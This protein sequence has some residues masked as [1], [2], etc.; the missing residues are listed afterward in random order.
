MSHYV[1]SS[2]SSSGKCF[3]RSLETGSSSLC[4]DCPVPDASLRDYQSAAIIPFARLIDEGHKPLIAAPCASGKSWM[5][6]GHVVARVKANPSY[7]CFVLAMAKELIVQNQAALKELAPSIRSGIYCAGLKRKETDF[8]ITF[9][10]A[11]SLYRKL[12]LITPDHELLLDEADQ[13]SLDNVIAKAILARTKKIG[14]FTGT[15]YR[16]EGGRILPI[17]GEG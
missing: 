14:G 8:N 17:F 15:P 7:R 11:Q 10:T 2:F 16:L 9:A 6:A 3:E 1:I 12:D 13:W 4:R 5:I